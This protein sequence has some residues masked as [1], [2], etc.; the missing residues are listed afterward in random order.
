MRGSE[1]GA[2]ADILYDP[3]H[4]DHGADVLEHG[5]KVKLAA[6]DRG[7]AKVQDGSLQCI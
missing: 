1:I 5:G 2:Y 7:A 6:R 3:G 4:I